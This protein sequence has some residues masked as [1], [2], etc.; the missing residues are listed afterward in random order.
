MVYGKIVALCAYEQI[1]SYLFPLLRRKDL[2]AAR[3]ICWVES[4]FWKTGEDLQTSLARHGINLPPIIGNYIT[5]VMFEPEFWD[6]P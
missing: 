3:S 2:S 1:Y 5:R 6:L 4:L